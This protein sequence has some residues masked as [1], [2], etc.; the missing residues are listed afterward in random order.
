MYKTFNGWKIAGRV[1]AAGERG[2]FR[3][4]YGDKMFHISQTVGRGSVEI[5][6]VYRDA[7]GRFIR[8]EDRVIQAAG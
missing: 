8:R 4:E 6:K 5:I 2:Q 1:V 7:H 3:N